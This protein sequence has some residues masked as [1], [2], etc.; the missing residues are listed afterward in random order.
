MSLKSWKLALVGLTT[1]IFCVES[2]PAAQFAKPVRIGF[3]DGDDWE[4]AIAAD[5]FGHLYA[6]FAHADPRSGI[7]ETR[8]MV[9]VSNDSGKTWSDPTPIAPP[10]PKGKGQFDPWIA[11]SPTD[12]RT[13]AI[14][15]L[16]GYPKASIELVTSKD[17]GATWSKPQN[18]T[19][20][21]P[22]LDKVV[23][24]WRG[25]T[26]ALAFTDY[27]VNT[28]AAISHDSG[29]HW[30]TH[31]IEKVGSPDQL[32][33]AGGGIDAVG[34]IYFA[35]NGVYPRHPTAPAPVW[36]TKS[37]DGGASWTRADI[38]ISGAPMSCEACSDHR[39]FAA[40]MALQI[41]SDD[42]VYLLWNSTPDLTNFAPERIYFSRSTDHG[43][44]YSP[45][46]D[47]SDAP[48]GIEHCFP[49]LI[50]GGAPG[51]VRIAWM[52]QRNALWNVFYRTSNDGG[53][54]F[55][56][57][58]RLST[59]VPGYQY[60]KPAGFDFPYGDYF[61]MTIDPQGLTHAVFGEAKAITT[62]GNAWVA[63]QQ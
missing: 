49:T 26:M 48:S 2:L 62:A 12:G 45:R 20:L 3:K 57:S 28:W 17:F 38:G 55:G 4:P 24:L 44:S 29:G 34:N 8:M 1:A 50:A 23:L 32:L 30:T 56:P 54:T 18:V 22:P 19:T 27:A 9:Q 15:L 41:G 61:Q 16:Q 25:N 37:S 60:L 14:G 31:L 35:W 59:Y 63:S 46:Q 13:V 43:V 51:D 58:V 11:I 21:S 39:Y 10:P 42:T 6:V 47:V 5:K 52:D 36:V 53:Q 33:T 7:Y 40:Q